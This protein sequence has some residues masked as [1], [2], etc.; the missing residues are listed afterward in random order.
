MTKHD[1]NDLCYICFRNSV[2][3]GHWNMDRTFGDLIALVHSELSEALEADRQG[4][5]PSKKIPGFSS[6]EEEFADTVMRVF[7]I[8]GQRGLDLGG[9]IYAKLEHNK[10]RPYKH[11]K[12]Y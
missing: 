2:F 1:I 5:Q 6:I 3:K 7:D 10:T 9:A 12:K 4:N 11:G 8:C